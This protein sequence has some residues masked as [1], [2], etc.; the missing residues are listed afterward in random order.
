MND[1]AKIK[2]A[3]ILTTSYFF[4]PIIV[5]YLQFRGFDLKQIFLLTSVHSLCVVLFE[6]PT[7][8]IAD[9]Y[10]PRISV[11]L[12][13]LLS[14]IVVF[15]M[16]FPLNFF[17]YL[18]LMILYSVAVTLMSGSDTVLIS[19]VS[20]DFKKDFSRI[21]FLAQIWS[22]ATVALGSV[23][24]K[25]NFSLTFYLSAALYFFGA[26]LV[27]MMNRNLHS[28]EEGNI[29]TKA[30][31]GL[32][33]VLKN[34]ELVLITILGLVSGGL[35]ISFKWLYN[36]LLEVLKIDLALWGVIIA[37]ASTFTALGMMFYPKMSNLGYIFPL[38][39]CTLAIF[40]AGITSF[41]FI[42]L[43][44]L[45][46]LHYFSGYLQTHT[47]YLINE[48]TP[49]GHQASSLSLKNMVMRI[50]SAGYILIAGYII[51]DYAF[52]NLM[53]ITATIF[54]GLLVIVVLNRKILKSAAR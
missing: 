37:L 47:D 6:Y 10:S 41:W 54:I 4:L 2:V 20:K 36:P 22:V 27:F 17:F 31:E 45:F 16:G 15:F 24:A 26:I 50:F 3:R 1:L 33:Y 28:K 48:N 29:F 46:V 23:I 8:V 34:K 13:Y 38:T 18:L 25:Y 32:F 43:L 11:F 39:I 30:K 9:Y 5:V 49:K 21:N 14:A 53:Y 51:S 42:A 12:G 40:L 19:S 44:G 52:S 7:G 35:F